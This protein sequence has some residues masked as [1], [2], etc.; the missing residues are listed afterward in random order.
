MKKMI[1][2][3]GFLL[4][5]STSFA[6]KTHI[7][8]SK[9]LVGFWR[10]SGTWTPNGSTLIFPSNNYKVI[11]AD[12]TYYTFSVTDAITQVVVWG[13]IEMTSDSTYTEFIVKNG[14]N[15]GS[16]NVRCFQTYKVVD[17]GNVMLS[18]YSIDERWYKEKWI[19]V[20]SVR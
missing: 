3:L 20:P 2:A 5:I 8:V 7:A 15:P 6:Q 13:K 17:D 19:R 10:Y 9:S 11:N 16:D 12:G 14:Q 1:F 4:L 18:K